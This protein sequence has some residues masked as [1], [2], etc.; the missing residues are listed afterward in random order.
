[1]IVCNPTPAMAIPGWTTSFLRIAL[2]PQR[3]Y[4]ALTDTRSEID[5]N[6]LTINILGVKEIQPFSK[7]TL[8]INKESPLR[9]Q[10]QKGCLSPN[11][12]Y[13][14]AIRK[15]LQFTTK[16]AKTRI[17]KAKSLF[18]LPLRD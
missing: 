10:I 15:P 16:K 3:P 7:L 11:K 14:K 18:S 4:Q 12:D 13:S 1:M 5:N 2:L 17:R 9:V 8:T 6:K